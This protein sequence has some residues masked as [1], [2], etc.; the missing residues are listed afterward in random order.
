[1]NIMNRLKFNFETGTDALL[2]GSFKYSFDISLLSSKSPLPQLVSQ[3]LLSH[4]SHAF[5][6][7]GS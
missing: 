7:G 4:I 2:D 5:S 1:M 6:F 3:S